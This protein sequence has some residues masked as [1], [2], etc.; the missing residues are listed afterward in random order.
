M[1]ELKMFPCI[2]CGPIA[3]QFFKR[4]AKPHFGLFWIRNFKRRFFLK[5]SF[6]STLELYITVISGQ[7]SEKIS[8]VD[9]SQNLN[10]FVLAHFCP[11]W[12]IKPHIITPI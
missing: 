5:I 12:S 11:F 7:K 8:R 10:N 4:L 6:S 3:S 2:D 9:F 1:R